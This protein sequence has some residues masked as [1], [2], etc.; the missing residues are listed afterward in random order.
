MIEID[1]YTPSSHCR[2]GKICFSPF[3]QLQFDW[4]F[5][6]NKPYGLNRNSSPQKPKFLP[7]KKKKKKRAFTTC[8][9]ITPKIFF[10]AQLTFLSLQQSIPYMSGRA[11]AEICPYP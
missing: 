8:L 1:R 10:G 4:M 6:D 7:K 11:E 3:C 5:R 2:K 9:R